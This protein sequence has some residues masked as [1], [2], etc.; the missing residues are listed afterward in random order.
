MIKITKKINLR[1]METVLLSTEQ[2]KAL[3]CDRKVLL[4]VLTYEWWTLNY[5]RN[6]ESQDFLLYG[7]CFKVGGKYLLTYWNSSPF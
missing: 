2:Q 5:L 3:L 4:K 6:A 1:D 7:T